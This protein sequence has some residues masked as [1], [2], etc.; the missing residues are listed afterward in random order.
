MKNSITP[1]TGSMLS[2]TVLFGFVLLFTG[3][4][5]SLF[6]HATNKLN[7]SLNSDLDTFITLGFF[8]ASGPTT[9]AHS[10][11]ISD[12]C[13]PNLGGISKMNFPFLQR[14][15]QGNGL[16]IPAVLGLDLSNVS[17]IGSA[18]LA[19]TIDN[20]YNR[21]DN[22]SYNAANNGGVESSICHKMPDFLWSHGVFLGYVKLVIFVL[23]MG[24][25]GGI[26]PTI[27]LD[28][29]E[30]RGWIGLQPNDPSV[31]TAAKSSANN[32]SECSG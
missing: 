31:S 15:I 17:F 9:N 21:T 1:V 18:S 28:W 5:S 22:G 30:R 10:C 25:I 2:T 29:A 14:N 6:G 27:A 23:V 32:K 13:V 8:D 11:I 16:S 4:S 12:E 19:H 7:H 24:V 26:T 3:L 20:Q